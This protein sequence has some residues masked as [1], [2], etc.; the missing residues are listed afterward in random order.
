MPGTQFIAA[1]LEHYDPLYNLTQ[2]Y[3]YDFTE[4][5]PGDVDQN[6]EYP[7]IDVRRYLTTRNH[8]AHLARVN[9]YWGGFALINNRLRHRAQGDGRY[10][11]EF[12]VMRRYRRQGVGRN[13]AFHM[14]D[15][16]R[17]YWEVAEVGPN[18][19]AIAFWRRVISEYTGGR[20]EESQTEE[21]SLPI[22]WQTF[23]SRSW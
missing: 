1:T 21:D 22:V 10:I 19:P 5:L 18:T 4:F 3:Q 15:S 11:A 13:M 14:F 17:G 12:F 9:G 2:F 8:Q 20:F 16:F 6:G 23:D 7:Y